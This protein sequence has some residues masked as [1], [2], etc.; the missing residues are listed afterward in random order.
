[1]IKKRS[2]LRNTA[3][4]A[5]SLAE[6]KEMNNGAETIKKSGTSSKNHT[7]RGKIIF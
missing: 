5:T 4:V 7:S 3:A 2:N 6:S 1:M